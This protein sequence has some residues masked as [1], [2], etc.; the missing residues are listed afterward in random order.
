MSGCLDL[1]EAYDDMSIALGLCL[2]NGERNALKFH[3][4]LYICIFRMADDQCR[5]ETMSRISK[6]NDNHQ[7]IEMNERELLRG[8][9]CFACCW[10]PW[11]DFTPYV[12]FLAYSLNEQ[13]YSVYGKHSSALRTVLARQY[14]MGAERPESLFSR[15]G[16][17]LPGV[18]VLEPAPI[19]SL[20]ST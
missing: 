15:A 5:K 12:K 8:A 3:A 7:L 17:M 10:M 16:C 20:N 14:S 9:C 4:N 6:L 11:Q 18:L 1:N 19:L 13:E 2:T